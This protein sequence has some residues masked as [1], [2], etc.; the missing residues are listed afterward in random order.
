MARAPTTPPKT[1]VK[2]IKSVQE[3]LDKLT[4]FFRA[5]LLTMITKSLRRRL[6]Y[7]RVL[8][9][10]RVP[11]PRLIFDQLFGHLTNYR[12]RRKVYGSDRSRQKVVT[13]L[14]QFKKTFKCKLPERLFKSPYR[15]SKLK[16]PLIL[17]Y[18]AKGISGCGAIMQFRVTNEN[19][20]LVRD[21]RSKKKGE[22]KTMKLTRKAYLAQRYTDVR[23]SGSIIPSA[24]PPSTISSANNGINRTIQRTPTVVDVESQNGLQVTTPIKKNKRKEATTPSGTPPSENRKRKKQRRYSP[25]ATVL[26]PRVRRIPSYL[27]DYDLY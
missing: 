10:E 4:C 14:A 26:T 13:T 17:F 3:L 27:L 22:S 23:T 18:A 21:M 11:M 20:Q 19:G 9:T 24:T 5:M 8:R 15:L 2:D 25:E 12:P 7:D 6:S 1:N 16:I